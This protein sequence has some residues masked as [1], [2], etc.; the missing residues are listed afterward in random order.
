MDLNLRARL[1]QPQARAAVF[2]FT[3][4][5][6]PAI[7]NPFLAIWLTSLGLS[8]AQIGI[9]SAAPILV[10]VFL[11]I[12]VGRVADKAGDWRQVI[13]VG[14]VVAGFTAFGLYFVSG[15]WSML[16]LFT[17]IV[18]PFQAITPVVDAA[19][20]RMSRRL[21]LDFSLIRVWGTVGFMV[22]T[23]IGGLVLGQLGHFMFVPL[24]ILAACIR[25]LA[26][27][28]L[29]YFRRQAEVA[30]NEPAAPT[31]PD[32]ES[33]AN[34][35]VSTELKGL[36]RPW[37]FLPLVGA[38]LLHSSHMMQMSMGALI[39]KEAGV[40]EAMIGFLWALAPAGEIVIFLAFQ[41][42]AKRFSARHL[43]L[44][45]CF[46]AI[47]RWGGLALEPPIWGIALFQVMHLF[48][49]GLSYLGIINFIANWTGEEIAAQ[50][51]STFVM[52]RQVFTVLALV[53]FGYLAGQIGAQ[54][55]FVAA[56]LAAI[57]GLCIWVSLKLMNPKLEMK[58]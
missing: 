10:M 6:A 26:S 4:F 27:L 55:Y 56:L 11:N 22:A 21:G 39:W 44:A 46:F 45:A 58:E 23:I 42:L 50:A 1:A 48:T 51:Q 54:S 49:F 25:A 28:Q 57:G 2:Y 33:A 18:V 36:L 9:V 7:S 38:A 31:V 5:M 43:L 15:F 14:S 8:R 13:I 17:L 30:S 32:H 3:L 20:I 29:P 16:M 12:L 35:L 52:I 47:V 19:T 34:P 53:G 40:P 37:F 24:F 41:R